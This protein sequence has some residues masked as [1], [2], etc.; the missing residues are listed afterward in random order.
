MS[1]FKLTG[2][3]WTSCKSSSLVVSDLPARHIECAKNF[4]LVTMS[5]K[6]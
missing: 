4:R 3:E 1:N 5:S 6:L 2:N